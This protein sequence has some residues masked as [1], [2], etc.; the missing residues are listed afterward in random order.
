MA[1]GGQAGRAVERKVAIALR[2][3]GWVVMKGTTYGVCDLVALKAGHKPRLIEVKSTVGGP[4]SHF[5]P[6]DR[7]A[8]AEQAFLAGAD[9]YLAWWPP[10]GKLRLIERAEWPGNSRISTLSLSEAA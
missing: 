8:L 5:L 3:D 2:E 10:R 4:Y 7:A 9:A 6:A 1:R